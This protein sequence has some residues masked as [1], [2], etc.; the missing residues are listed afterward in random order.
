M[1]LIKNLTISFNKNTIDEKI[2]LNNFSL[3]LNKGDFLSVLGVNGSGKSTLLNVISGSIIPEKGRVFLN[4]QDITYLAQYKR[5]N[6]I[7]RMFQNP[8]MGTAP[9]MTIEENLSLAIGRGV[10]GYF[11]FGI[12]SKLKDEFKSRLSRFGLGL[13]NRLETKIKFLSG[14]ERQAIALIM[15]TIKIPKILLLDEHTAALDPKTASI[16]M[17]ETDRIIKENSITAIMIT[18][19]KQ[20]SID[21]SNKVIIMK[22]GEIYKFID[23]SIYNTS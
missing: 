14:G 12:K 2:G 21:Y 1:L 22:N 6:F 3:K 8:M 15:A 19:N 7:G 18:H 13:E 5:A 17:K 11:S 10:F 9:N 20:Q 23:K 4:S 16:V